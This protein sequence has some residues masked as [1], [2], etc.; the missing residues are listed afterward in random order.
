MGL[1]SIFQ[2]FFLAP[3][4]PKKD[5]SVALEIGVIW[6]A[7][8]DFVLKSAGDRLRSGNVGIIRKHC[9]NYALLRTFVFYGCG[10]EQALI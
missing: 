2:A 8:A 1:P 4:L 3:N 7:S 9:L 10:L 6:K 5:T